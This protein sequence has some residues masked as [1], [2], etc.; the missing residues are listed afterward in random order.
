MELNEKIKVLRQEIKYS[1]SQLAEYL[2][3]SSRAVQQYEQGKTKPSMENCMKLSSL[4]K[5][6]I[7]YL[8]TDKDKFVMDAVKKH[9]YRGKKQAEEIISDMSAMFAGG[10]LSEEDKDAVF[11]VMKE[12]YFDSKDKNKKFTPKEFKK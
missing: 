8:V 9:S 1:Q 4:F 7:D 12:I 11:N 3:V 5:V 10:E 2:G 6:S